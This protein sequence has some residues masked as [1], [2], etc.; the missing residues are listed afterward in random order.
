MRNIIEITDFE[1]PELDIYARMTENQLL[2]RHEPEKGMFI[3]ES[4]KVIA[5]ALE[6]G[7]EPVS[8]LAEQRL[9]SREGETRDLLER[10]PDVP[11]YAAPFQVL[12]SLTG[13]GLTRGMLCAMRPP[14][15]R[16]AGAPAGSPCWSGW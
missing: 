1:A 5:R 10:C 9:V 6:A 3:A 12:T 8:F 14:W 4:P 13:F 15:S 2:N 7:Y 16:C 11:V